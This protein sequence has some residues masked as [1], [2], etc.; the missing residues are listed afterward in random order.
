[1]SRLVT[2]NRD[3]ASSWT[4]NG[5]VWFAASDEGGDK[6]AIRIPQPD[7]AYLER[8]P[9]ANFG[10]PSG[11]EAAITKIESFAIAQASGSGVIDV[12]MVE[13]I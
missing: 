10:G 5:F 3:P 1:M 7:W 4:E 13:R 6:L 11:R 9:R 2:I 8:V 12:R